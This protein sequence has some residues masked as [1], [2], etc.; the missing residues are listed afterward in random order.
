MRDLRV[1]LLSPLYPNVPERKTEAQ[2][3]NHN[4][5]AFA[6]L[7]QKLDATNKTN[8]KLA[9]LRE[10]FALAAP[11]DAAWAVYFLCGRKLKRLISST[12]LRT[13]GA[14]AARVPDWLFDECYLAVGDLAE[15]MALL[16]PPPTQSSAW[17]LRAWGV[18]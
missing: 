6:D 12:E 7:Y 16:L 4:M 14:E 18:D 17:P 8:K 3:G 11:A 15:T 9:A 13:W 1:L 2:L 5:R 10:Y